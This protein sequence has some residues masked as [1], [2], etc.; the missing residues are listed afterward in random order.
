V[1]VLSAIRRAFSP[2]RDARASLGDAAP[3]RGR[4]DA[5]SSSGVNTQHWANADALDADSANSL[6][7]RKRIM[8]RSRYEIANN[9]QAKGIQLT[10]AN[11]VVGRGPTLRMQTRNPTFNTMVEERWRQWCSRIKFARKLRTAI[12]AKLSDGESFIVAFSN[13]TLHPG[14]TVQLDVRGV[15]AEQV[16]SPGLAPSEEMRVDGI[17]FDRYG[18]PETYEILPYHPGGEWSGLG[19]DPIDVPAEFVCHLYREDRPGQHRGI[20]ELTASLN[21]FAQGRRYREA[22]L[23]AAENIADF[24]LF[25]KTQML[26]DDGPD[27]VRPMSS[28][29]IEKGMMVALPMGYDAYQPKAEQP[30]AEYTEFTRA[31][32]CEE[33]RPLN[34]PYNIAAADSSGYSF[35]GGKLDHLTY[36]VSIDT[37]RMDAEDQCLDPLFELWF[38]EAAKVYGWSVPD[39]P[40]P[41]H[42]WGWPRKPVIDEGKMANAR[43]TDLGTGVATLRR[44]YADEGLDFEDE[45]RGMAEDYGIT[46]EEMRVRLLAQHFSTAAGGDASESEKS[47]GGDDD[48]SPPS[49]AGVRRSRASG[50]NGRAN[51][52]VAT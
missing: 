44:I 1:G 12:K 7:V 10:H 26:G 39:S 31:L 15:E 32:T 24:S 14:G 13:P 33:A 3:I 29:P 4:Y 46:V 17:R 16:T 6:A 5:A 37:E 42:T 8:Q 34:M 38:R 40:S 19:M 25:L 11:Y 18:N 28:L 9:G 23:A 51:G 36:F 52:R 47:P 30:S 49:A 50:R 48:D 22:T 45:I 43:K 21:L 2:R 27:A 41:A 20:G 35:S